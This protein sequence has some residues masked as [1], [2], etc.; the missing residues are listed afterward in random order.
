MIKVNICGTEKEYD[1]STESW[2]NEQYHKRKNAGADFWFVVI[3]N[4]SD[5]N[6]RFPSASAPSGKGKPYSDFNRRE[7]QIIDIWDAIGVKQ[8]DNI[9]N[10]LKFLYRLKHTIT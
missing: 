2:I 8:D 10:L 6:L 5:I 1:S 9:N 7:Q 3:I 4:N